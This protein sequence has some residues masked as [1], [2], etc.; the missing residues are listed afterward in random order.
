LCYQRSAGV[1]APPLTVTEPRR[2]GCFKTPGAFLGADPSPF[3]TEDGSGADG[4][5]G[6]LQPVK[7]AARLKAITNFFMKSGLKD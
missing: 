7:S 4:A 3:G 2:V 5:S 6:L 1:F